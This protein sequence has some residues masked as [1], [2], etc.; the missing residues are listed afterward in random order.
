MPTTDLLRYHGP[1]RCYEIERIEEPRVVRA[2]GVTESMENI[3]AEL[4]RTD[5]TS[6]LAAKCFRGGDDSDDNRS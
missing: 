4:R 1:P 2:A 3:V 5:Q 6:T